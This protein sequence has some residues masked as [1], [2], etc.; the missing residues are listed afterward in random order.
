MPGSDLAVFTT[1]GGTGKITDTYATAYASPINDDQQD[2]TLTSYSLDGGFIIWEG[3]RLLKTCD[4]QDWEIRDDSEAD[5]PAHKVIAAW[6]NSASMS[7]HGGNRCVVSCDNI[8]A[9]RLHSNTL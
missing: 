4:N 6:G 8:L 7:Y 9:M 3:E 5:T 1:E 2:W